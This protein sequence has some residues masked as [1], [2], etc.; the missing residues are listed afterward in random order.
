[1]RR[2]LNFSSQPLCIFAYRGTGTPFVLRV[3]IAKGA[4]V[5]IVITLLLLSSLGGT[6]LYLRELEN[7]RKLTDQVM[8]LSLNLTLSEMLREKP[9]RKLSP[10]PSLTPILREESENQ[11]EANHHVAAVSKTL[12]KAPLRAISQETLGRDISSEKLS[13]NKEIS[14]SSSVAVSKPSKDTLSPPEATPSS[15]LP[16]ASTRGA[17]KLGNMTYQCS[18]VDCTVSL[19]LMAK[20]PRELSEGELSIV[21]E[22]EET[23]MGID[24]LLD[25]I[26]KYFVYP[27]YKRLDKLS[28]RLIAKL[29][30][31]PFRFSQALQT[32]VFFHLGDRLKPDA[33]HL[34]LFDKQ[35]KL[36][37]H[38]TKTIKTTSEEKNDHRATPH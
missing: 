31:K 5:A 2:I 29:P 10:R 4:S 35:G 26:K 19:V 3:D 32:D 36:S 12:E 38:V 25:K 20:E 9:L 16:P 37:T 13:N 7:N 33:I 27:G 14:E 6:L 30:K 15:V 18:L 22:A 24:A 1:M 21:L 11:P 34:Y 28:D 8:T 23:R 17:A